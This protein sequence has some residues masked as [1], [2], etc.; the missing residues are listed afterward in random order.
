MNCKNV[1]RELSEYL[2]SELDSAARAELERHLGKCEDCRLVVDT[3]KKTIQ[4]FCN[5]EPIALPGD[6][7]DRLH[8][9]LARHLRR[10]APGSSS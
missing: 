7:R 2:N 4:I 1:I 10:P 8:S 6:V 3:T 9:A 5:S